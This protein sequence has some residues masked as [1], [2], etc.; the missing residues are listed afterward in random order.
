MKPFQE[1]SFFALPDLSVA[2]VFILFSTMTTCRV[3]GPVKEQ[4][5][6]LSGR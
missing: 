5:Q 3:T 2:K 6:V 1:R 4:M